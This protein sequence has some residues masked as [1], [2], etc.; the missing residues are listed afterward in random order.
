MKTLMSCVITMHEDEH[1]YVK[2]EGK[3]REIAYVRVAEGDSL[4]LCKWRAGL[5]T[6]AFYV[7]VKDLP[8]QV[9]RE[10][11]QAFKGRVADEEPLSEH[12]KNWATGNLQHHLIS[13]HRMSPVGLTYDKRELMDQL[14]EHAHSEDEPAIYTMAD[15]AAKRGVRLFPEC[16][17]SPDGKHNST[18]ALD[19]ITEEP[20]GYQHC[21]YCGMRR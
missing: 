11:A 9:R 10:V 20:L 19:G 12:L 14:H 1:H 4:A 6:G 18:Q 17:V 16:S 7:P 15:L 13:G 8:E 2:Y 21:G 5:R 3:D